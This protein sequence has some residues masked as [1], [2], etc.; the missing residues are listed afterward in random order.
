MT[1]GN[2]SLIYIE[3]ICAVIL[4]NIYCRQ[5]SAILVH[6][7]IFKMHRFAAN[8]FDQAKLGYIAPVL[9]VLWAID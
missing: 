7:V 5:S 8:E 9:P 4:T 1:Q 3:Q 2:H 6:T